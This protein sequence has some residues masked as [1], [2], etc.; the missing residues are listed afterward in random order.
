V[1][2]KAEH[3][4]IARSKEE[5]N[6]WARLVNHTNTRLHATINRMKEKKAKD[7]LPDVTGTGW[8]ED[9][10]KLADGILA[11]G[12]GDLTKMGE[13]EDV[14]FKVSR[15]LFASYIVSHHFSRV[16]RRIRGSIR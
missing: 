12:D 7:E 11:E 15:R 10:L 5:N 8:M 3:L 9:A 16:D 13:F 1:K 2:I 14:E 6:Q 4:L